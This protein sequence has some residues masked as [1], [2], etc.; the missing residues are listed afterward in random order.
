MDLAL[1]HRMDL[2]APSLRYR[3]E[4]R[5]LMQIEALSVYA[6]VSQAFIRLS[7]SLGCPTDDARL[8]QVMLLE[9]LFQNYEA[10]RTHAGLPELA[11]VD[12]VPEATLMKLK[13]GNALITLL[14]FAESRSSQPCE[15]LRIRQIRAVVETALNRL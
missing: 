4:D 6:R 1:N 9:W 7:I 12:G 8:S 5:A 13:M 11:P 10:V 15:K 2:P 14:E 3:D